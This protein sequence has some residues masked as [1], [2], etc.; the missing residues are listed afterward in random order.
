MKNCV[1]S[2]TY[3][4][5]TELLPRNFP[6]W[7]KNAG[8]SPKSP[9]KAWEILR[10]KGGLSRTRPDLIRDYDVVMLANDAH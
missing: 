2:K 5:E 1:K 10:K 8:G 6:F 9:C 4:E 7:A 3:N